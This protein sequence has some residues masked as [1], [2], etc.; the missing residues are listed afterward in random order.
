VGSAAAAIGEVNFG[1][2]EEAMDCLAMSIR[3]GLMERRWLEHNSN[4]DP[5]RQHPRYQALLEL[6]AQYSPTATPD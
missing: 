2:A 4:L 3:S 5:V 6:M 1:K